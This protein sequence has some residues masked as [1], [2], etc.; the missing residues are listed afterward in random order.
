MPAGAWYAQAVEFCETTGL[1]YGTGDNKFSPD[2]TCTR[3]Q[4]ATFLYRAFA[5]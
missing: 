4:I 2:Q 3:G 5:K 1:M